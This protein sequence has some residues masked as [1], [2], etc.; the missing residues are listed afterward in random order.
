MIEG[1]LDKNDA[2]ID[3][4]IRQVEGAILTLIG[5]LKDKG[6]LIVSDQINLQRAVD[7]RA[8]VA[9]E[10][11]V[12]DDAV[13]EAVNTYSTVGPNVKAD[14]GGD[15]AFTDVD[16]SIISQFASDTLD[17]ITGIKAQTVQ[18]INA[19]IYSAALAGTEKQEIIDTVRQ[20]LVGGVDKAGRPLA[21]A[22]KTIVQTKYMQIDAVMMKTK[23]DEAGIEK[24]RYTGSLIKDSR[25]W[26]VD[27]V[28]EE[29]T[30]DQISEWDSQTWQ[31]KSPGPSFVARGGWNCRHR[32]IPVR[33]K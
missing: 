33:N 17:T 20:L 27:H 13:A 11:Q 30:P 16:A 2:R 19:A 1:Q 26:C 28:G 5:K 9:A 4:A 8:Q 24:Y 29:L 32:W 7:L 18:D 23:G 3:A 31:G 25:Q 12:F 22:A 6:G 21:N 10:F 14:F 15:V